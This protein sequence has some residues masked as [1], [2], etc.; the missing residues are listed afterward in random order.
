M[1]D[2]SFLL[3]CLVFVAGWAIVAILALTLYDV[4]T[5]QL[6]KAVRQHP[7]ARRWRNRPA[8]SVVSS[9]T[10][11]ATAEQAIRH[12][13]YR[14]VTFIDS[15]SELLLS[16]NGS[17]HL[18]KT[19]LR[20]S[21]TRLQY[22]QKTR[23]VEI[24]PT[25]AFPETT[26]QFFEAYRAIALAPFIK[27]RA[28]LNIQPPRRRWPTLSHRQLTVTWR[29]HYYALITWALLVTNALLFIYVGYIAIAL[30]QP[31]YLLAYIIVFCLWLA[32][33]IANHP[34]VSSWQKVAFL[35]LAPASLGYFLWRVFA[36]PLTSIREI[37]LLPIRHKMLS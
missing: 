27:L 16:M 35:L 32:W 9:K 25:L 5:I 2:V 23:F 22:N 11:S 6:E 33:S 18:Y 8:I 17:E 19:A 15:G 13:T 24:I 37:V 3:F 12:G 26:Q 29:E 1:N 36:A 4:R 21:V 34:H 7:H 10:L 30:G 28:V 31:E 14:K 20:H